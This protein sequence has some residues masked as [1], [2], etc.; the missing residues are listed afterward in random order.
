MQSFN[1]IPT[2]L[3]SS[4]ITYSCPDRQLML[5]PTDNCPTL[6]SIGRPAAAAEL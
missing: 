3:V 6:R 1:F 5:P 4:H 2:Q